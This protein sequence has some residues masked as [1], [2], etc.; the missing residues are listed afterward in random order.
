MNSGQ[1]SASKSHD[2]AAIRDLYQQT[3]E[4]W[5]KGSGDALAAPYTE[6]S[7]YIGFDGT[8][9]KGRAEI[10]S[11]HQ[12]LFDKF[13][14]GS[15]LIGKIRS[16]RVVTGDVAVVVAVG[17]TVIAGQSN[18]EPDRNSIHTL[19]AMKRADGEWR[20]TAF[21]NTRADFIGRPEESQALTEELRHELL[22][23]KSIV[24]EKTKTIDTNVY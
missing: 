12:M 1:T 24:L 16:V 4:G 20:F 9:L 7:D 17:G 14:K 5:N 23:R 6:D 22:I 15:R 13:I 3:I 2:E 10:A 11:F 19:V 21:Q 8:Y 18:I